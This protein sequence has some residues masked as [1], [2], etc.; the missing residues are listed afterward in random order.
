MKRTELSCLY[1]YRISL[2]HYHHHMPGIVTSQSYS[3][4]P[5]PSHHTHLSSPVT[6]DSDESSL[7]HL[8][9]HSPDFDFDINPFFEMN[10]QRDDY[11]GDIA[12]MQG[13]APPSSISMSMFDE[14]EDFNTNG[15]THY[16]IE[17]QAD[18]TTSAED[19]ARIVSNASVPEFLYQLTKM[20]SDEHDN[21]IEWVGG[22]Y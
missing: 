4:A 21:I 19:L 10:Y 2:V 15:N 3:A 16:N 14:Y 18:I 17:T 8:D 20:L 11:N 6:L 5:S 22:K 7:N 12:H 9:H 13:V 1:R